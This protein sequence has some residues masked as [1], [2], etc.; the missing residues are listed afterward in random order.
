MKKWITV[1]LPFLVLIS[2]AQSFKIT[3]TD[4]FSLKD[5]SEVYN[6]TF[7]EDLIKIGDQYYRKQINVAGA[8][9]A[10]FARLRDGLHGL[11]LYKYSDKMKEVLKKPLRDGKKEFGILGDKM[12]FFG[13]RLVL[14]NYD[15][16]KDDSV[17]LY[18]S[19]ID[20][21]SLS[22]LGSTQL[23]S[24]HQKN[25]GMFG[26][27]A[28]ADNFAGNKLRV[29]FSPDSSKLLIETTGVPGEI[30]TIVINKDFGIGRIIRSSIPDGKDFEINSTF[31]DNDGNRYIGY[32]YRP[33]KKDYYLTRGV[34]FQ[35]ADGKEKYIN[36]DLGDEGLHA[37]GLS[38][39]C[40]AENPKKV[41]AFANYFGKNECEG[42]FTTTV[43]VGNLKINQIK[44]LPYPDDFKKRIYK[45]NFGTRSRDS[46]SVYPIDFTFTDLGKGTFA[47]S[48]VPKY[49]VEGNRISRSFAGPIVNI[50]I[51]NDNAIFNMIPR[52]Q[53]AS[54]A[55][56]CIVTAY[57][58]NL[59]CIYNDNEKNITKELSD[60]ISISSVSSEFKLV[61]AIISSDGNVIR[62]NKIA[63][64]L[65]GSS[66]YFM[67]NFQKLSATHFILSIGRE[68]VN[69]TSFYTEK[70]QMADIFIN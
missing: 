27:I 8:K 51:N 34:L 16:K 69:M 15:Y 14:L 20:P 42:V 31:I 10:Y 38:F 65:N 22:V 48:G 50:F 37:K 3:L 54:Q 52:S 2:K 68:R 12:L 43:D 6:E 66:F 70:V 56:E 33:N 53:P 1:F 32:G 9:I 47:L 63:E 64:S 35:N 67:D 62:R 26:M 44:L 36:L 7:S 41:Y 24:Y 29:C 5:K 39:N 46:Y 58:N 40:L 19:E 55:S 4:E 17:R 28:N 23:Y 60:D 21:S 25:L 30:Y 57:N 45:L 59:V 11:T 18:I 61:A 49:T 13:N